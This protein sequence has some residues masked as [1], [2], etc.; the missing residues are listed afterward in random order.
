MWGSIRALKGNSMTTYNL[1]TACNSC[2]YNLRGIAV[3]ANCP[4]CG[5]DPML[6]KKK[7]SR[8]WIP[9]TIMVAWTLTGGIYALIEF[10]VNGRNIMVSC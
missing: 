1:P 7:L 2:G 3:S 8:W 10:L 4:E 6:V 5:T 9:V